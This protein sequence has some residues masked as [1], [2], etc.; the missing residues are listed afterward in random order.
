MICKI[1]SG[2]IEPERLSVLPGTI[3]CSSCS[4]KYDLVKPVKGIL[5]FDHKT[6]GTLQSM[7]SDF[8][9]QNKKY[10]KANGARSVVKNFSK[11]VCS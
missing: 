11:N 7:S 9:E 6:G 8:Y 5:V 2:A 10:F 1:C 3:S 4:R